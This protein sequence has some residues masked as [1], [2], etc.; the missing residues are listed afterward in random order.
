MGLALSVFDF[1]TLYF[2]A[3][4]EG[5]LHIK[6]GIGLL[7]NFGLIS[8]LVGNAVSLYLAK[9]YYEGV[10]SIRTS[11]A[12]IGSS[13]YIEKELSVLGAMVKMRGRYR[14]LI[15]GFIV[16]GIMS[17]LSNVSGHIFDNPRVRWGHKVFD[18][19]DHPFT[20]IA[21][22]LH[23]IYTWIIIVPFLAHVMIYCSFQLKKALKAA[24][25]E[26]ALTYD[27][28]NPDRRGGFAFVDNANILFN[29]VIA[30][31][32]IQVTL[33]IETFEKMNPEHMIAYVTL[34]VILVIVNRLFLGDIY[35]TIKTLRLEALN[36][37]K[38][39]V[40]QDDKL[41]FEILKYCYERR[42]GF[43]SVANFVIKA[44]AIVIPGVV[45]AWP[46]IARILK[47]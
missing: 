24:S 46:S 19:P 14:L 13:T 38:N 17:W 1:G 9:K 22:R 15:Y 45:K 31:T 2:A 12:V 30:L 35:T 40:Y 26:G 20:F 16:V 33:H 27:V 8:T 42:L 3:E 23:N 32:Y 37:V 6:G 41:S 18:S 7:N 36:K 34:T 47:V 39:K 11:K 25:G 28:L 21:S 5:V 29:S 4:S 44:A 43:L 10:G